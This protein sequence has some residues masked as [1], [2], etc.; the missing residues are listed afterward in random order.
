MQL[1]IN[2]LIFKTNNIVK[3]KQHS[4]NNKIYNKLEKILN[5]MNNNGIKI[6]KKFKN[7]KKLIN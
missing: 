3:N 7:N 2:N 6:K 5:C 1:N 4:K